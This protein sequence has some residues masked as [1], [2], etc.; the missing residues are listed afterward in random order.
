MANKTELMMQVHC[1]TAQDLMQKELQEIKTKLAQASKTLAQ[2][3]LLIVSLETDLEHMIDQL[4]KIQHN[5]PVNQNKKWITR[6]VP[7]VNKELTNC[8]SA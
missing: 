6:A 5:R 4:M 8:A 1:Q 7:G 3:D 2:K